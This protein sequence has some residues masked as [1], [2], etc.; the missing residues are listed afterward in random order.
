MDRGGGGGHFLFAADH[1][2]DGR[3]IVRLQLRR[4]N[5]DEVRP[6]EGIPARRARLKGIRI[7][8]VQPAVRTIK[9]VCGVAAMRHNR[10]QWL[11]YMRAWRGMCRQSG[12]GRRNVLALWVGIAIFASMSF[13]MAVASKGFLEA[14]ACTHYMFARHALAEPSYLVNVWGRPLCTCAYAI[15]AAIGRVLGVRV[16]SLLLAVGMGLVTYR[17]AKKQNYRMPRWRRFFYLPNRC[18]SCTRSAS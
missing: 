6:A 3:G 17:I 8:E 18:F 10:R 4:S 11:S 15:P 2:R 5:D 16:M 9:R 7:E 13:W 12:Q 14:D 1:A